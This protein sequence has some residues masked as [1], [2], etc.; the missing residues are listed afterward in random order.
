VVDNTENE[1]KFP[2]YHTDQKPAKDFRTKLELEGK[3]KVEA[4]H[5]IKKELNIRTYDDTLDDQK[6]HGTIGGLLADGATGLLLVGGLVSASVGDFG[7]AKGFAEMAAMVFGMRA[8]A[9]VFH[10]G[11]E[12]DISESR[13]HGIYTQR[14]LLRA[15][16]RE[17]ESKQKSVA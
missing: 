7:G 15:D 4:L 8:T 11:P 3:T 13:V 14:E 1:P 2:R 16:I 12:Y 6:I 17:L 5:S 9:T 10:S